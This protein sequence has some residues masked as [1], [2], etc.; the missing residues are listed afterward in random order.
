MWTVYVI[1]HSETHQIYIGFT[2]D[3]KRRIAE[4]NSG[5]TASTRRQSGEWAT[6]YLEIFR[7]KDDAI[8]RE[9]RLKHHGRAK[10]EL[11][12]RIENSLNKS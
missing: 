9:Y 10:Q 3:F 6:I 5:S 7:S 11:M 4:H 1:Q 12:K 8:K 2:S